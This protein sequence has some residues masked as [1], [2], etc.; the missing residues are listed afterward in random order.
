MIAV[1]CTPAGKS[2][3]RIRHANQDFFGRQFSINNDRRRGALLGARQI[4]RVFRKRQI[5]RLGAVRRRKR[6]ENNGCIA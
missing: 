3:A 6:I 1:A 5:A 2:D 4:F